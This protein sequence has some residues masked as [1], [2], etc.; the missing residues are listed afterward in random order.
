V[1]SFSTITSPVFAELV[2]IPGDI[3]ARFLP[4]HV[5]LFKALRE[6]AEVRRF[7]LVFLVEA[8]DEQGARQKLVTALHSVA[9]NG[10]LDFLDSPPTIRTA[11][12]RHHRWGFLDFY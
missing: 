4:H 3:A 9:A 8:V 7:K 6:M 10:L 2:I 12:P 1:E 5:P 11:C